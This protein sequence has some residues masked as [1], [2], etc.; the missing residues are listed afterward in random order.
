[1]AGEIEQKIRAQVIPQLGTSDDAE[2]QSAE[3]IDL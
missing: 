2:P 3:P 1:M